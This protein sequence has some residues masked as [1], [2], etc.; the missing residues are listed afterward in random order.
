[1]FPLYDENPTE[2]RPIV[3]VLFIGACVATWLLVQGGGGDSAILIAS[4]CTYGMIPVELTGAVTEGVISA[5]SEGP[6]RLGGATWSTLLTSM[7]LHG[8]WGHLLGNMWFL[9]VFGNNIEDSMGH[10]RFVVFYL[11]CGVGA[12]AAQVLHDPGSAIPM[13]GASG[14]IS[15]VMGAY[16]L[17]YPRA[18]VN[19]AIILII[20][21]RI[22]PLP[23]WVMLGYWFLIQLLSGSV[24]L[25]VGTAFWA[26][27]GGFVT[28]LALIKLFERPQLV[29][30]K[31]MHRTLNPDE[32]KELGWW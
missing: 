8:G 7:F 19:T 22:V 6:C 9:W 32:I 21:I 20:F 10:A 30:A 23:A 13:V 17:L 14:A 12:A 29:D 4:V 25:D 11:L 18:R 5:A 3:T 2:L 26:H 1:M 31:R 16:A 27:I 24:G 28:G 15:G